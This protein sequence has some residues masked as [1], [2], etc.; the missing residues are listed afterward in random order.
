MYFTSSK[1][2]FQIRRGAA[3]NH[4]SRIPLTH[5]LQL[6]LINKKCNLF[7]YFTMFYEISE[8]QLN[9]ISFV[10]GHSYT[11]AIITFDVFVGNIEATSVRMAWNG[12][13][14]R[15]LQTYH[16]MLHFTPKSWTEIWSWINQNQNYGPFNYKLT[17]LMFSAYSFKV[18]HLYITYLHRYTELI[19][20]L[21][22]MHCKYLYREMQFSFRFLI[23]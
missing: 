18:I 15:M 11:Y 14:P 6:C 2:S 8:Q 13:E 4:L 1:D 17:D 22:L 5:L 21:G 19:R 3:K 12:W 16:A 7:E 20:F 9:V 23:P 10:L